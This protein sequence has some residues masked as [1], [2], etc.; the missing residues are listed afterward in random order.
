MN[1]TPRFKLF[2][3]MVLE[4]FIWG[5]WLPKIFGYLPAMG[6]TGNEQ[7]AILLA[8]PVSAIVGM[9]FSNE[10][11]DRRFAAEKFMAFS[12]FVG[13]LAIL[14]LG[15]LNP[16]SPTHPAP[17]W[18]FFTLMSVHCLLYVP[19]M[20]IANTL[21]F[22]NIKDAARDYGFVRMGGTVGWILA[23]WPFIFL[24][25]D[26]DQVAAAH[27]TG[28]VSWLGTAF[29]SPLEGEKLI[30]GTRW[31]YIVA[32]VAS[33]V[34]AAFSLTLPN[35]P[36]KKGEPGD[37]LAFVKA[38]KVLRHPVILVLW[39]VTLI[40][41]FVHNTYF[42]HTDSFLKSA[43]VGIPANWTQAVMSVGQIAEM[44]TM[45][46]LGATLKRLGWKVTMLVGIAGHALRFLVYAYLP[47]H[48]WLMVSVQLIH[49]ICYAFYF[50]TV[51][52][53]VEKNF[54]NDIR[55]SAQ[56]LFNLM[57]FGLGDILAKIFWIYYGNAKFAVAGGGMDWSKLF[58]VPAA[59]AIGAMLLL[60]VAFHPKKELTDDD[61]VAAH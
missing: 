12:H 53:F 10:F 54:P 59:L 49:G 21:V 35:T 61:A 39:L 40:D 48:Q 3:M 27:T 22:A 23:A 30:A 58:L 13:G 15:F 20:S 38:F 14:A 5:A 24:L 17:F 7:L 26:W 29:G 34:L 60:A 42:F 25:V 6:F 45:V 4:F 33:L 55:T 52:I 11:A 57:I 41:S 16:A 2:L 9:V 44:L 36:P 56:G 37:S 1:S 28:F 50:A 32:G 8:F 51:Y 46:I 19:T 31:T 43:S 47:N 18:A